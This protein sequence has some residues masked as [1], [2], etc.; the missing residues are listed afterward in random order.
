MP[1]MSVFPGDRLQ[2]VVVCRNRG[3]VTLVATVLAESPHA[4]AFW[5]SDLKGK[6]GTGQCNFSQIGFRLFRMP[7]CRQANYTHY[8]CGQ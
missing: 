4:A 2:D 7:N 3:F 8:R 5:V 6:S 1:Q